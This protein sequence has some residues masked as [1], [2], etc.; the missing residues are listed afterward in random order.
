[1]LDVVNESYGALLS[2]AEDTE[3]RSHKL[4]RTVFAEARKGEHEVL[5]L[6]RKWIDSPTSYFDNFEAAV[7]VQAR[8]QR[9][10]LEL[11]RD[12]LRGAA[13]YGAELRRALKRFRMANRQAAEVVVDS[14][15]DSYAR[16]GE[17]VRGEGEKEPRPFPVR[18][19]RR[20]ARTARRRVQMARPQAAEVQA[21][22]P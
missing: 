20:R 12:A 19:A 4:S 11:A 5:E 1:M 2:A 16:L 18:P 6:A 22:A 7:D 9:R 14:V 8:A 13:D 17:R 15:R 3:A 21:L 10:V